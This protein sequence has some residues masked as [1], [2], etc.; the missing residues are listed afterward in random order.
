MPVPMEQI[1]KLLEVLSSSGVE[2]IVIGGAAGI[3]HGAPVTTMDLDIVHRRTPE[4][5]AKLLDVPRKLGAYFHPDLA[6]RRLPPLESDLAGHGHLNM[7]T[8]MGRLDVLCE[9]SDARGYDEL[10]PHTARSG[11]VLSSGCDAAHSS[12]TARG[13]LAAIPVRACGGVPLTAQPHSRQEREAPYHTC[14]RSLGARNSFC[15]G[16]TSKAGY[17]ASRL[18]TVPARYRSGAWPSVIS[19]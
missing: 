19:C 6:Q 15:P 1:T 3:L 11:F 2:F 9:V 16:R 7:Q 12:L 14:T 10:L 5:I 8:S 13:I 17:Q 18:R 4:N